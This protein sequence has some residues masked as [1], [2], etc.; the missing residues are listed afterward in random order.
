MAVVFLSLFGIITLSATDA[1]VNETEMN[2]WWLLG[3]CAI[4]LAA[5]WLTLLGCYDI[6]IAVEYVVV[7]RFPLW[8]QHALW[9]MD[10]GE[11]Y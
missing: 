5:M 2:L 7:L 6:M 4:V 9:I 11:W 8:T 1:A 3:G 10:S